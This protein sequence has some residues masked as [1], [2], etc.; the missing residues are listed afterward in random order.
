MFSAQ[1][2][3]EGHGSL[4]PQSPGSELD[5][6]FCV[7]SSVV[8]RRTWIAG[9]SVAWKRIRLSL[10]CFQLSGREK[11]MDRWIL[12]RLAYAVG[13]CCSGFEKYDFP[14]ATTACYNFW[15][16]ELCDWY[17]VSE[18]GIWWVRLVSGEWDWYLV[19]V[20]GIW[21]VRLVS[22]EWD[23]YLVSETGMWWVWL[24]SGEWDFSGT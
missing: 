17:L 10:L 15:L 22:G 24:V 1:W 18:T 20:T 8:E 23:W 16:Y 7:F 19:S 3:R 5:C 13:Q 21:W 6:L 11:D 12:S 2:W 9:S 4:D 14:T